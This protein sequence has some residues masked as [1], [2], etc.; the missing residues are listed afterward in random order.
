[1]GQAY[2]QVYD[3]IAGTGAQVRPWHFQWLAL[4]ALH[5]DLKLRL[6][7]VRGRLLDVGCGQKPYRLFLDP[8]VE[9]FGVDLING[10]AVDAV[11]D[12]THIPLPDQTFDTVLCT[13]V[14]EHV[15]FAE[16]LRNEMLRCLKP[17]GLLLVSVPFIFNEHGAPSDFRRFTRCGLIQFLEQNVE[18]TEV[19]L[20]GGVGSTLGALF[21]NWCD[22]QMNRYKMTRLLKGII[23]PFFLL[24]SLLVNSL[25]YLLDKLDRT[26]AFYGN[27]LLVGVK[28][29]R[30][31]T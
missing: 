11:I 31:D 1:V 27:V 13:Q 16:Q 4:Y 24:L 20:E 9:D 29:E 23:L 18:I 6:R 26:E 28:P 10:P 19:V 12:G 30:L 8:S 17:G 2:H 22:V 21:L 14:M 3:W 5:H 15:E 7:P 25:G